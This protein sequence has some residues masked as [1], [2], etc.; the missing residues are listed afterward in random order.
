VADGRVGKILVMRGAT[1]D[2]APPPA[3]YIAASG[4]IF[5]DLHIHDF[6]A[7][8]FVSGQEITAVYADGAALDASWVAELDDVDV[9]AAILRLSD[10]GLVIV[11]A[12]R[13]DPLDYDVRL[14]VFG[15][16][17]S[18]VAGSDA[19]SP[20]R[21]VERGPT[22]P[23]VRCIGISGIASSLPT[24]RNWRPSSRPSAWV[25]RA[26]AHWQRPARLWQ[27]RWPRSGHARNGVRSRSRKCDKRRHLRRSGARSGTRAARKWSD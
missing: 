7:V 23:Q 16:D 24:E 14:E 21:S 17:D 12:T 1:H 22:C 5:A 25:P 10:G 6:D 11:S 8:R 18:I 27:S 20:L 2:P 9:A 15:T 3:E 13:R 19:R 26:G 4:G